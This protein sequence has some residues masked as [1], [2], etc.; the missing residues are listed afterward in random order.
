MPLMPSRAKTVAIIDFSAGG[1]DYKLV[2]H[3]QNAVSAAL[4]AKSLGGYIVNLETAE[5]SALV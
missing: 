4:N 3:K 1:R 5:E 2:T